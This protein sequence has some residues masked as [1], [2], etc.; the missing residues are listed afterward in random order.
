MGAFCNLQFCNSASCNSF[1]K[2]APGDRRTG[3]QLMAVEAGDDDVD[4][5]ERGQQQFRRRQMANGAL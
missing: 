3:E 1:M 4:E 2:L 5:V